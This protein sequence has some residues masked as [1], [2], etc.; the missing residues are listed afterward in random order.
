MYVVV[1]ILL[2]ILLAALAAYL[3]L[4]IAN[5]SSLPPFSSAVSQGFFSEGC[6]FSIP[7]DDMLRNSNISH[8]TALSQNSTR[9]Q[10]PSPSQEIATSPNGSIKSLFPFNLQGSAAA[11]AAGVGSLGNATTHSMDP[12]A[13]IS[14]IS[15]PAKAF[16]D[17][18]WQLPSS[19]NS[20]ASPTLTPLLKSMG[21]NARGIGDL[22]GEVPL[23]RANF[24]FEPS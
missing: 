7:Y 4:D 8:E 24:S 21:D 20:W 17:S 9:W 3:I 13:M 2:V 15:G 23:P 10:E 16:K 18:L 5:H 12:D 6:S 19:I 11:L 1:I 22:A 14:R